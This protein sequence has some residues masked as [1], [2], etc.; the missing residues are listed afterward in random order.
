M[1]R[2]E[3]PLQNRIFSLTAL[4][5]VL[6]LVARNAFALGAEEICTVTV[7]K[8]EGNTATVC[9]DGQRGDIADFH[10]CSTMQADLVPKAAKILGCNLNS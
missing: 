9:Y 8:V 2:N 3:Y 7:T 5:I 1:T 10:N 4:A 6:V